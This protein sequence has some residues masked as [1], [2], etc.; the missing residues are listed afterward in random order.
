MANKGT[1]KPGEVRN[2]YGRA[3]KPKEQRGDGWNNVFTLAGTR[4]D[5]TTQGSCQQQGQIPLA[6]L[7]DLYS[8]GGIARRIVDVPALD[9][10]REWIEVQ[11]D[12]AEA[13]K[14][15]MDE[16]H[17]QKHVTHA[18][19]QGRLFGGALLVML[20]DDGRELSEPLNER[21][22]NSI[23]GFRLYDRWQVN[24]TQSSVYHDPRLPKYGEPETYQITP[25][26]GG[27]FTVHESRVIRIPGLAVSERKRVANNGWD[28]S[29][30]EVG[31]Q[32]L[33][34]LD[35]SHRSS[36]SIVSDFVQTVMS[37]KGLTDM[38]GAGHE[39]DVIKRLNI[40]D[41]SRSVLNTLLM[42]ADGEQ[43]SKQASS[44]AG[45][46]DLLMQ[47]RIQIA[48]IYGIPMVKLFGI[49]P[50]GLNA[51]GEGDIRNYYDE[52]SA[53]QEFK[54]RPI[55]ERLIKIIMLEKGGAT[56]GK[57]P[58]SWRLIF[59][60]LWQMSD[61][62]VTEIKKMTAETDAIYIDRGVYTEAE[63]AAARSQPEGWKLD[64]DLDTLGNIS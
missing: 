27:S 23:D 41:M 59:N 33:Q 64:I 34:D 22:I 15:R 55:L 2:P 50:G 36:A 49:S 10:C 32:A 25:Y 30:L 57:E 16:L 3:G 53:E 60:P 1:P 29:V 28:Y 12:D 35:S 40:L 62:E 26:S 38:I 42:D 51:T 17:L 58:A 18:I 13:I 31:Y 48:G 47:F 43:F 37:I 39:G 19:S 56:N 54:L 20:L 61:K 46:S 21:G 63:V 9:M 11:T 45:L 24:W 4:G 5:R 8:A 6:E 52:I 7:D 14:Q 44:V